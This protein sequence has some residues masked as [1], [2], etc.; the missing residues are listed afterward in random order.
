[1]NGDGTLSFYY[2]RDAAELSKILAVVVGRNGHVCPSD[3]VISMIDKL[4]SGGYERLVITGYYSRRS[5]APVRDYLVSLR[6]KLAFNHD[7][8]VIYV[9][10]I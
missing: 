6:T 8:N 3:G 1:M 10:K 5:W 4:L 7:G 2:Y 9:R